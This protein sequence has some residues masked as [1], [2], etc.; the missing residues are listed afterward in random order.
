MGS[1]VIF[2]RFA[3]MIL[4]EHISILNYYIVVMTT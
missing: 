3:N 1:G 2:S 4:I